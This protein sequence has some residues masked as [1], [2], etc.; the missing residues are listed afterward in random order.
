MADPHTN[1]GIGI[2]FGISTGQ[3]GSGTAYLMPTEQD[4]TKTRQSIQHH[5]PVD[6]SVIGET[7]F[8]K[9][10]TQRLRV[11]PAGAT[12]LDATNA[13]KTI[14]EP[15]DE[16]TLVDTAD[17]EIAGFWVVTEVGKQCRFADKKYWDIGLRR[18]GNN[19]IGASGGRISATIAS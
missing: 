10:S 13:N 15:G 4:F 9:Q 14:M 12:N 3:I 7:F 2:V 18:W 5:E 1:K 16:V 11:Y 8:E 17:P 19:I 6:G